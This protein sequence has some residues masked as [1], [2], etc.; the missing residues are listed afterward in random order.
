MADFCDLGSERAQ[1]ILDDA[2][3]ARARQSNKPAVDHPFCLECDAAI[4]LKRRE[5]L[6]GVEL[7]VDC[8]SIEEARRG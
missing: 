2:L 7:C 4:P 5:L 8:Q 6:P 1:Q 3:A